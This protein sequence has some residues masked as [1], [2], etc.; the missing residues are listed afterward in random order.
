[1]TKRYRNELTT[2][3]LNKS[4]VKKLQNKFNVS[5]H[6]ASE[7]QIYKALSLIVVDI[8]HEK[9]RH[10]MNNVHSKGQKQVYYL[11]ME[12]LMGRSLKTSL[13]NLG[14]ID[15]VKEIFKENDM[16]LERIYDNEPDAGLGNG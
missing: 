5:I 7:T 13:Y 16:N 9:R 8:L 3:E 6:E 10:F 14:L 2:D 15:S 11:S 1:M 4:I 12:F